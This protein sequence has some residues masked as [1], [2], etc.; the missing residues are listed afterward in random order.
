MVKNSSVV[1]RGNILNAGI[2]QEVPGIF[3]SLILNAHS[4]F[5]VRFL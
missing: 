4:N 3:L 1:R 5:H 2:I